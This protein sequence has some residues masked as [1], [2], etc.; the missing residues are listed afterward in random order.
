MCAQNTNIAV[1]KK[2]R[3]I[4]LIECSKPHFDVVEA[5]A[6]RMMSR[7][8]YYISITCYAKGHKAASLSGSENFI[9]ADQS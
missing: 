2:H 7:N 1:V 3:Y 6:T 9:F 4:N 8:E 5:N